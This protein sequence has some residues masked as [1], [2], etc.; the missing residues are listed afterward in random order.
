[1]LNADGEIAQPPAG[2]MK[3]CIRNR[4][5]HTGH[6]HLAKPLGPGAI[7]YRV[8]FVDELDINGADVSIHRQYI[9]GEIGVE[10]AAIAWIDLA[11]F[12]QRRADPPNDST[13]YLARR[14]A[15]AYDPPAIGDAHHA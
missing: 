7:K 3:Y 6:H 14:R 2:R 11:H 8:G 12:A 1:M 10:E 5:C 4:G 13:P 9:F 15:W